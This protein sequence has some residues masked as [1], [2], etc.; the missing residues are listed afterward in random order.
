MPV[1]WTEYRKSKVCQALMYKQHR[2]MVCSEFHICHDLNLDQTINDDANPTPLLHEALYVNYKTVMLGIGWYHKKNSHLMCNI[3]I[4]LNMIL[5]VC[6]FSF[7]GS[8]PVFYLI[9]DSMFTI[10]RRQIFLELFRHTDII[11][12]CAIM[13]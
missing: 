6:P 1:L 10:L 13:H 2:H 5:S 9:N 3:R 4:I 8:F 12:L 7:T 11:V